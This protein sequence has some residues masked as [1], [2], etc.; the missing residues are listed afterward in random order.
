MLIPSEIHLAVKMSLKG[1]SKLLNTCY[2]TIERNASCVFHKVPLRC[3]LF[4]LIVSESKN[5]NNNKGFFLP[6]HSEVLEK[7]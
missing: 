2:F 1:L 4:Q 7:N 5:N 3:R 6:F